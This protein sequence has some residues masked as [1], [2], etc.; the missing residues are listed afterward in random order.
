[1]SET[2]QLT[3]A[4]RPKVC[5]QCGKEFWKLA[6]YS[7]AQWDKKQ[8]CSN[9]CLGLAR[10]QA[11]RRTS[12]GRIKVWDDGRLRWCHHVVIEAKLGRS[13]RPGEV[14]DHIDGD[15]TN[16]SPENLRIFSSHSE[17]MAAH[18]REGTLKRTS[19]LGGAEAVRK[20]VFECVVDESAGLA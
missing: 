10:R 12:D 9:R 7:L 18:W 5:V 11:I 15:P 14:V 20:P 19:G 2:G 1:M 8:H 17:H 13:L 16:N 3:R 4:H 6:K